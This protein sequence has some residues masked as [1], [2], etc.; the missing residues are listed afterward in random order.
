MDFLGDL[1]TNFDLLL[2]V[3]VGIIILISAV[4]MLEAKNLT[5][6]I[7]FLAMAFAGI[8]VI[9]ILLSAEFL[10]MIQ[11]TVYTGGVIVLFLF[12]LML[13]RSEQFNLRDE[14]NSKVNFLIAL[15]V[16]S[17]FVL[18]VIPLF[19]LFVSG[20]NPFDEIFVPALNGFPQGIAWI[21]FSL[22]NYYQIGFIILGLIVVAAL[23]GAIY[24]VKNEPGEDPRV[25]SPAAKKEE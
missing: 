6:A 15:L 10:A 13:T 22:F 2:F 8:A 24:I 3:I 7:I 21:G 25:V 14:L 9:Y 18:I 11:M 1:I 23:V 20:I 12:A 4:T 16:V 17:L 19:D 5:H